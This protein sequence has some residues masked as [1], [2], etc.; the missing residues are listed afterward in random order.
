MGNLSLTPNIPIQETTHPR[1]MKKILPLFLTASALSM[2]GCSRPG[3][4][5]DGVIKAEDRS[6]AEYT[7][8]EIT[9][10][11]EVQWTSGK[12]A[13]NISADENLLPLIKTEVNGGTLVISARGM[14]SPTKP[15][16][17]TLSSAALAGVVMNGGIKFKATQLAGAD[18]SLTANGTAD[19]NVDGSITNLSV[20][21]NGASEFKAKNLQTH[22]AKLAMSGASNAEVNVSDALKVTINGTGA[23]TY[24]GNPKVDQEING[25]GSIKHAP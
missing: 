18:F 1:I 11:Y 25:A 14:L 2:A 24:S 23:V 8:I 5:G 22:T 16:T 7:R 15:L 21:L 20:E 17:L 9:G 10:G 3:V 13:L 4:A 19:I 12:P 6:V